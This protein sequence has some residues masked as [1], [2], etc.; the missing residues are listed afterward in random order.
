MKITFADSEKQSFLVFHDD[1][2]HSVISNPPHAPEDID[3]INRYG[4]LYE[5][6]RTWVEISREAAE[7]EKKFNDFMEHEA[8]YSESLTIDAILSE[9]LS[10]ADTMKIKMSIFK[11]DY[12]KNCTDKELL[13]GLRKAEDI[14]DI[15]MYFGMIRNGTTSTV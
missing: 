13:T 8:R 9:E 14:V 5:I 10:A 15:I 2:S 1:G 11:H 6:E 7:F 3:L 4:G 12:V